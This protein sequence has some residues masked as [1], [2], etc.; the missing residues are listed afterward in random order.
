MGK[1]QDSVFGKNLR[2]FRRANGLTQVQIAEIAE[3]SAVAENRWETKGTQPRRRNV[4]LILEHFGLSDD[5]LLSETN[6]IYAQQHGLTEAPAG[7]IAPV[8]PRIVYAPLYGR[9]HAGDADEPTLLNDKI[10]IPYEVWEHHKNG[11]WLEVEGTCMDMVYP[12][13]CHIF[14]DPDKPPQNGS[15]AVVSIDGS[16]YVMRRLHRG[17]SAMLLSPESHDPTWDDIV[18]TG[19]HEVRMVGT[20]VWF[21]ASEEME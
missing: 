17:A 20:V 4:D 21:Q 1:I 14:I 7:A 8:R 19:D 3:V 2:A 10:P 16:E 18:V 5:D 6:G 11:Y 12:P 9:V 13:G 15:I